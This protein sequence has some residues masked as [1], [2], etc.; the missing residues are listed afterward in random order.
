MDPIRVGLS[1]RA[2]RIRRRLTQ[3][4][5]ATIVRVSRATIGRV[6]RGQVDKVT[7]RTLARIAVALDSRL[8]VRVLWHGEGLDRLLDAAHADLTDAVLRIL[9]DSDWDVATEVSFNVRGDRGVIDILAFH[10]A[11]GSLLVIEIKSVVPDLGA[12]LGTLDRK[13]RLAAGIARDRGWHVTSVSRLLV[14][15]DDR[16]ARR[17]VAQHSSIFDTALPGRTAAVRRWLKVPVG[18]LDGVLFL[19]DA[20]QASTRHRVGVRRTYRQRGRRTRT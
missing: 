3:A 4:Q 19:S 13:A 2:L 7:F 6:E 20:H 8:E 18:S 17:R 15:P 9:V 5:L 10:R 1:L 16:T 11:S 12:M 14:L